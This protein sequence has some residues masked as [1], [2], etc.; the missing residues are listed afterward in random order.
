M[1]STYTEKNNPNH[2]VRI[3][4]PSW[5][6]SPNR[7]LIGCSQIAF[8]I[9]VLIKDDHIDS[10]QEAR[11]GLSYWTMIW[12]ICALVDVSKCLDIPIWEFSIILEH[13]PF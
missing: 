5:K 12:A 8:P 9:A 10:V 3:S 13:L 1:S 6:P 4:I 2:G 7:I 11:P